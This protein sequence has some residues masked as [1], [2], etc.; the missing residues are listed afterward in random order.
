MELALRRL[1]TWV[2]IPPVVPHYCVCS[3]EEEHFSDIEEVEISKFSKRTKQVYW[4]VTWTL[5]WALTP[6]SVGSIP[7]AS[8]KFGSVAKWLKALGS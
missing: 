7:T 1:D 6:D 4:G 3:S 5:G 2:R 8:A